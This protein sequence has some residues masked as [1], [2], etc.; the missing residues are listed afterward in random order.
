MS[1]AR[2]ILRNLTANWVGHGANLVVMFFL[3]PYIVHTLGVTEYGIWQ[4]LTVLTG[5][6]GLLDLG[7]RASTGRYIILYLGQNQ[8]EKVDETIRTGLGLYTALSSLIL[9][10]GL[11]LG[12]FFPKIFPSVP[13]EY[14]LTVAVLLP[15]LA[16][17]IWISA[18]RTVLSSIL[19]AY[20]R[21]DLAR[22]SDLIMLAVRTVMTIA[23]LEMG[24][25]L[26]GLTV[27]VIGCNLVGLT[28]NWIFSKK[29]HKQLKIWP[30][31]LKKSRLKELYNYGIGAFIV[32]ASAK[33]IGQTD[34]VIVG[35]LISIDS[36]TIYSVGAMLIYYSDTFIKQIGRTFFPRLQK[37]VAQNNLKDARFILY[38]QIQLRLAL[39]TLMYVGYISFGKT[40]IFLWMF[41][42]VIFPM[43]SV[44]TAAKVMAILSLAKLLIL[45]GAFSK[46]ILAAT[47]H[48]G[49]SA[50]M[51]VLEALINLTFSI[52]LV[53][54]FNW[55]LI[56]I[57]AGTLGSHLL[58]QTIIMP[59]YAC[60]KAG[61]NWFHFVMNVGSKA[62]ASGI[63][64]FLSCYSVQRGFEVRTWIGFFIQITISAACYLPI[65]WFILF[66]TDDRKR[67]IKK[68]SNQS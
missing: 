21:F 10:A 7:V 65:I 5:Y 6:M 15:T 22:G 26:I 33:I 48:I 67:V 2:I 51:T 29:I 27:A 41:D 32:A 42:P 58:I 64:F 9:I 62:L 11:I 68:F 12:L 19:S 31:M 20:D 39:G 25:G 59:Y 18:F 40:F 17:N 8:H 57:A 30:L 34:L 56:G 45:M 28:I 13:V 61:I 49:F 16:I 37:A 50:K 66:S 52:S 3:S 44:I 55:G 23:A 35:N 47:G 53:I 54:F 24:T 46:S 1:D 14:H 43:T 36:V 4:L 60:N 63:L 38:R